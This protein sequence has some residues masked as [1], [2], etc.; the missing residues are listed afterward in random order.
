MSSPEVVDGKHPAQGTEHMGNEEKAAAKPATPAP[1]NGGLQAWMTVGAVWLAAFAS[2]GLAQSWGVFQ[3]AFL[4][5]PSAQQYHGLTSLRLGFLGGCS[6]GFAFICGPFGNMLI[7]AMGVRKCIGLGFFLM[8][9]SLMMASI[10]RHFWNLL[11]SQGILFGIGASITY[12]PAIGLPAQWFTTKRG[13]ATGIAATGSPFGAIAFAPAIR[14][15]TANQG[16]PWATRIIGFIILACGVL[17][18]A[19]IQTP[20]HAG[21]QKK[22]VTA[23]NP[24]DFALLK[25]LNFNLYL[26][27]FLLGAVGYTLPLFVIPAFCESIGISRANA[28]GVISVL[29]ALNVVSRV[30]TGFLGDKFGYI[31]LICTFQFLQGLVCVVCWIFADSLATMMG[32]AVLFGFFA[33][34][35]WSL[36]VP[37]CMRIVGLHKL[38]SAL[39]IQFLM[40]VLPP[41]FILP[42]A[43]AIRTDTIRS[44]D[45]ADGQNRRSWIYVIVFSGLC[46]MLASLLLVPV[47]LRIQRSL[48]KAT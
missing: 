8:V 13:I 11:L 37:V 6:V 48:L 16:I 40:A 28:A 22:H 38:G 44:L 26:L 2:L 4:S 39:A 20:S 32:F 18:L 1:P 36:A 33:G 25:D 15:L 10:G 27:F 34:A 30:L 35:Y 21:Q 42:I 19:L 43:D 29:S 5:D 3:E 46:S 23:Y 17:S 7:G 12:I 24:F 9:F 31:N 45:L 41:I 14:A 47:R